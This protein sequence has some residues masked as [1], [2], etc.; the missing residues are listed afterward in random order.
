VSRIYAA[1]LLLVCGSLSAGHVGVSQPD[2][3]RVDDGYR[4]Y[5]RF[6]KKIATEDPEVEVLFGGHI[7][8]DMYGVRNAVKL[9]RQKDDTINMWRERIAFGIQP[10]VGKASHDG[11]PTAEGNLTFG[12]TFMWRPIFTAN[13]GKFEGA[14]TDLDFITP[15]VISFI[16]QAWVNL[17]LQNLSDSFKAAPHNVKAGYFPYYVGRGLSLGDWSTGGIPYMGFSRLG[18]Q[19]HAPKFAPGIL[20]HGT[21]PN[22][23]T[24][25]IYYSPMVS[26]DINQGVQ[27]NRAANVTNPTDENHGRHIVSIKGGY[28]TKP[29]DKARVKFEPYLVYYDSDRQTI[30]SP[31][32]APMNF[33]TVGAMVDGRLGPFMC[34]FEGAVQ[35]G[36]Q[37]VKKTVFKFKD[38]Y[39]V[40][41]TQ[42]FHPDYDIALSGNMFVFDLAYK[43]KRF[44]IVPSLAL[45]YFSGGEYPYNDPV[46]K[47]FA[48]ED[49]WASITQAQQAIDRK[50]N[51]TFKGF[52]PLRDYG[53]RGMWSNPLIMFNAGV[54]P[55]PIDLDI[56]ALDTYN[57]ADCATNLMF[58]GGGATWY[59]LKERNKLS[60]SSNIFF[61]WEAHPPRKWDVNGIQPGEGGAGDINVVAPAYGIKGW[62]KDERANPFL[63]MEL[64]TLIDYQLMR[65][66]L[67]T[68]RAGVFFPGQ[69]YADVKG[70]PNINT[71]EEGDRIKEDAGGIGTI[72]TVASD[73]GLGRSAAY[74]SYIRLAYLF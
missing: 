49:D 24:Y 2:S 50:K 15:P 14:V 64:N 25:E 27:S 58:I 32:D 5:E 16:Q 38:P 18:V 13:Y 46:D 48:R 54:V 73:E 23:I 29:F 55:R 37:R 39:S 70:Q 59:P 6:T 61:H 3:L 69:L 21:F 63:G 30:D 56:Y 11:V 33:T 9:N 66:C 40:N 71:G 53:Y 36:H 8:M 45:G 57:D 51:K 34:N 43:V 12:S 47:F 67:L 35:S 52:I 22:G 60:V 62:Y 42:E 28:E 74:G 20:W 65:D 10:S 44:P 19:S 31:G 72:T 68:F 4:K 17:N 26:E 41:F 7:K 1:L